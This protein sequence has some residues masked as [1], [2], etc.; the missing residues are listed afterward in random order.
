[1][2]NQKLMMDQVQSRQERKDIPYE[3]PKATFVP[4]TI[5]ERM[6]YCGK[7][8]GDVGGGCFFGCKK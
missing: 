8:A 3:P 5:E 1:M 2:E 6:A 7:T 4:L